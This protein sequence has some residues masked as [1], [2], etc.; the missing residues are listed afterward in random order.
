MCMACCAPPF[1]IPGSDI[2]ILLNLEQFQQLVPETLACHLPYGTFIVFERVVIPVLD[3]MFE[4]PKPLSL[5]K[6]DST[7]RS[8]HQIS[9]EV[10]LLIL[11]I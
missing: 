9:R 8:V 7:S 11:T 4:C 3:I 2:D 10:S 5:L 1:K 6:W